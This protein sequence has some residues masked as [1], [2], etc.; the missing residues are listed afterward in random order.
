MVELCDNILCINV[1]CGILKA[2]FV[3][4]HLLPWRAANHNKSDVPASYIHFVSNKS[5]Q[6]PQ[7]PEVYLLLGCLTSLKLDLF[8]SFVL[9][10]CSEL[11]LVCVSSDIWANLHVGSVPRK[12]CVCRSWVVGFQRVQTKL[13]EANQTLKVAHCFWKHLDSLHI[14]LL[15]NGKKDDGHYISLYE[16]RRIIQQLR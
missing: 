6:F 2:V 12:A 1:F 7:P 13:V 4:L 8:E 16:S 15:L 10:V 3:M 9:I 11:L 5:A 14:L